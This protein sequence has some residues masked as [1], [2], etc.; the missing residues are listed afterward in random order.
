[1]SNDR[2]QGRHV[3]LRATHLAIAV[4]VTGA[5]AFVSFAGAGSLPGLGG[6]LTP[7]SGVWTYASGAELPTDESLSLAGLDGE[8]TVGYEESGM[9]HVTA[10]TDA[11]MF[12]AIGYLHGTHRLF[13]MDLIRRQAAGRLAEILG[14]QGLESDTYELDIGIGRAA[15]RDWATMPKDSL[16]YDALIQY[17]QGVN[18]AIA[19]MQA[20]ATLPM[21]FKLLGYTPEQWQPVDSLLVQRLLTQ[22]LSMDLRPL[23]FTVLA[24]SI[25]KE[26]FDT[27]FP[28]SP[29]NTQ[30]PFDPGPY[31][32]LPLE[33]LPPSDPAAP[34]PDPLAVPA[35]SQS[36]TPP[37]A[38][39]PSGSEAT[40]LLAGS[41]QLAEAMLTR[42]SGLPANALHSIGNSNVWVVSGSKTAS[43]KPILAADPHLSLTLPSSWFQLSAVSPTYHMTG[44]TLPGMP[45]VLLGQTDQISFGVANSQH[46]ATF[47]YLEKTDSSKPDQYFW[48]GAW[49]PME[50]LEYWVNVKGQEPVKHV[51]RLTVH[52]PVITDQGITAAMWWVGTLPSDN[53]NS[54][55]K[56]L[57][58]KNFAEFREALAGW[59]T[60][61]E[62]FAYADEA[63]NI[64]IVN[65][66]YAP[67]VAS[68]S[69]YLPLSGTGESDVIGTVPFAALPVTYNPPEGFAGASNQR[70]VTSEY[71]YYFG[72]GYDFFDQGWRQTEIV[73]NLKDATG[74]TLDQMTQLQLSDVD[75]VARAFAPTVLSALADQELT[76]QESEALDLLEGWDYSLDKDSAAATIWLRYVRLYEYSVFTPWWQ[77]F[78]VPALPRDE[79]TPSKDHGGYAMEALRGMLVTLSAQDPQNTLFT[80]PE[81]AGTSAV[82]L[83]RLAFKETVAAVANERGGSPETWTYGETHL[84]LIESLLQNS[85]LDAG[86][87]EVGSG[88]R[89]LNSVLGHTPIRNGTVLTGVTSGGAS[90]RFVID[91]GTGEAVSS[92]PGGTSENPSSPWYANGVNGWL[93]GRYE[94]LLDGDEAQAQTEG[95]TW[96]LTR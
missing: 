53:L 11:D 24:D 41:T 95:R 55:L 72:R 18:A 12:R 40:P 25:G 60:P 2:P 49:Q 57:Q 63:G 34:S 50:K 3:M 15:E 46:S 29:W 7:G 22:T 37:P 54:A 19:K 23:T 90:W 30:L 62:N 88:G 59:S 84:L 10:G 89:A 31:Q 20:D 48:N 44:V 93:A 75:G 83:M 77:T 70:E 13:Q 78:A 47:F 86:P 16:A 32:N 9:P 67:Q 8:V 4:V 92:Y 52:G 65:A 38:D 73:T 43:G 82:E 80:G 14:P 27:W 17:T 33:S 35:Q 87:F 69:P 94:P 79:L 26:R 81:G 74:I 61:A 85:T 28:A 64:G 5:L 66:G 42:T 36:T 71:P 39:G 58:A 68:G 91:W 1:M 76:A 51:V 21:Y 45:V 96:T 6:L 56:M